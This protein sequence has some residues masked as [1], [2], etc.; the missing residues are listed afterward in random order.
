[1]SLRFLFQKL[2]SQSDEGPKAVAAEYLKDSLQLG[3]LLQRQGSPFISFTLKSS[4][5][6]GGAPRSGQEDM[7]QPSNQT[8]LRNSL[9]MAETC[10][11]RSWSNSDQHPTGIRLGME[12]PVGLG[13]GPQGFQS[14]KHSLCPSFN[15]TV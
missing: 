15:G 11:C 4:F 2:D 9:Q 10:V 6:Q 3:L 1:M 5:R 14:L 12:H 13:A 7:G 8:V